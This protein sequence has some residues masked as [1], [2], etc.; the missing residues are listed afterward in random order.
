MA[1]HSNMGGSKATGSFIKSPMG[2]KYVEKLG[3]ESSFEGAVEA[4]GDIRIKGKDVTIGG[5]MIADEPKDLFSCLGD[6]T[7]KAK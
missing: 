3:T 1:N 5:P 2:P 7:N 6:W 4:G